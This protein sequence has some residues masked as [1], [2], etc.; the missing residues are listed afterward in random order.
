MH[1]PGNRFVLGG[2]WLVLTLLLAGFSAQQWKTG[3]PLDADLFSLLPR[4]EQDPVV[5]A[6][7]Q[8][9]ESTL[10]RTTLL[11]VG[12]AESEQL[13]DTVTRIQTAL[14]QTQLFAHIHSGTGS[15]DERALHALLPW[16]FALLA[17]S[18]STL[19]SETTGTERFLDLFYSRLMNPVSLSGPVSLQEDL[20]GLLNQWLSGLPLQTPAADPVTGLWTARINGRT[21]AFLVLTNQAD[22]FAL[23]APERIADAIA[24][25]RQQ[26]ASRDT[27]MLASGAALFAASAAT[28]AKAEISTVGLGSA[29]AA[30]AM[31]LLVFRSLRGW[32]ALL[33]ILYGN[34]LAMLACSLVFGKIHLMTLV[35]GASLTG[36][37]I[38]YALHVMTDAFQS[39]GRWSASL[40]VRRLLPGLT[41]GMVTSVLAYA[42][43]ALAPFPGLQQ[44]ALFSGVSLLSAF[45]MVV[46][47]FP[48]LL[49]GFQRKH[50]PWLLR[51]IYALLHYRNALLPKRTFLFGVT[52]LITVAGFTQVVAQDSIKMLY[53][54]SPAL[55]QDDEAI[56]NAFGIRYNSQFFLIEAK[57]QN[58]LLEKEIQLTQRLDALISDGKLQAYSALSQWIPTP[59]VQ[60]QNLARLEDKVFNPTLSV[61]TTLTALGINDTVI[62]Q[63]WQDFSAQ[64]HRWLSIDEAMQLP[65]ALP[66]KSLWLGQTKTGVASRISLQGATDLT[67]LQQATADLKGIR[68][69]DRIDDI[70]H[71]LGRYRAYTALLIGLALV[72]VFALLAPR[73]GA[74]GALQVVSAPALAILVTVGLHG[75]FDLNFNLFSLFGFLIVLGMGVDYAIYFRE[76][77]Q[78]LPTTAL[79]ITLDALTTLFSFGLLAVS[80]T[81]A[82]SAFGISVLSGIFFSW[83]FA[84]LVDGQPNIPEIPP[85]K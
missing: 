28:Q 42:C 71:L 18:Q 12:P 85:E 20:F 84:H 29:V 19:L 47:T 13:S 77:S 74:R 55:Q 49:Q 59:A 32:L 52:V 37:S 78:H 64:R 75:W 69:I 66:W 70:S 6:A 38:D 76:S 3:L 72:A 23:N 2:V 62:Q 73:Y 60:Q 79:G 83:L 39:Q 30:L 24:S 48:L 41:L 7:Q 57:D 27:R 63:Q 44:V 26:E 40:A 14:T 25:I 5:Q 15:I 21:G 8:A 45:L 17:P 16:R 1:L 51:A 56:R 68:Y 61:R 34:W 50:T 65:I 54:V 80:S 43:L 33:P 81:P 67:A 9:A 82:V 46:M 11:W 36:V 58:R 53:S 22:T 35:F 31:I 10:S 4:A